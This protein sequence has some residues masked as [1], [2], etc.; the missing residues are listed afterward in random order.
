MVEMHR[1]TLILADDHVVVRD[2]LVRLLESDFQVVAAVGDGRA[3]S[4]AAGR[5]RPDLVVFDIGMPLLNGVEAASQIRVVAPQAKIVFLTQFSGKDYVQAAFRL[6]ASAYVLKNSAASELVTALREALAGRYYVSA[7][8]RTNLPEDVF[9]P[10][11]NPAELFGGGLTPR[12]R[13]VLQL[14]A[15]GKT[16]KEIAGILKISTKTVEF[17]KSAIMDALGLRTTAE[18]TRYAIE[19]GLVPLAQHSA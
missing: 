13:E 16:A 5:L 3:L 10:N 7:D 18:L 8:L 14:V 2:G 9:N 1:P 11:A 12:Q 17:H 4:E 19:H 15:E 6:G